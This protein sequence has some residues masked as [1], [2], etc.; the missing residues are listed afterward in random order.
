M[1]SHPFIARIAIRNWKAFDPDLEFRV[2]LKV[3]AVKAL[4]GEKTLAPGAT[5]CCSAAAAET[6]DLY[7][8]LLMKS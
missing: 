3:S 1:C 4:S 8:G 6:G 2:V 7:Y 5:G